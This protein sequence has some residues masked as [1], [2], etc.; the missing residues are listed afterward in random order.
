MNDSASLEAQLRFTR[1]I[2]RLKEVFR[3]TR[4]LNT[5]RRENSAEHSWHLAVMTLVLKDYADEE[6]DRL[7]V[8]HM[9]LLHDIVE[10]DAGDTFCYD[11]EAVRDQETREKKA[12]DRI[13]GMLPVGQAREFREL[14]DEFERRE[15]PEAKFAHALD[16]FQPL[17]H[18]YHTQGASWQKHGVRVD[19]VLR[20][21]QVM[22]EGSQRLWREAERMIHDAVKKGWL[23]S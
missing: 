18:N 17:L 5:D 6:I 10:I 15:T 13:F 20:R 11:D 16:R 14:W 4:L 21:N 8:L 7:R 22:K 9:V 12:A 23:A 1:E 2:D 3:Q 19:Q